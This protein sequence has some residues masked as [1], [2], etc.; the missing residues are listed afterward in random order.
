MRKINLQAT[1]PDEHAG[2]RLD[3]SLAQLFPDFSRSRLQEWLKSGQIKLANTAARAKDKVLGGEEVI[4]DAAIEEEV[5]HESQAIEIDI[6]Y[7]DDDLIVI[8]KPA[9]LVVHPAAG[10]RN[11]TLLNALLHHAPE[12]AD[13]PRAGIIHRIDKDTTGLLVIARSIKAHTQ[14]VAD[15][16]E[17]LIAREYVAIASGRFTAGGCVDEPMARHPQ[18]RTKMAVVQ[19]GKHAITHYRIK[20]RFKDYTLLTVTLETGRTHQIRVHMAHI[21]HPLLGDQTYG[22]RLKLPKNASELL[23]STLRTFKRQALHAYRL[24]LTHPVTGEEMEWTAP[25]PDDIERLL[26]ILRSENANTIR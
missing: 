10:N 19:I 18:N 3:Q 1:I 13:L 22:G 9:G 5:Q 12:L 26:A 8:N 7:Q 15:L 16:Q 14:L 20:E 4:I 24:S 21:Q 11:G 2:M 25:I 23:I 17:H 6:I